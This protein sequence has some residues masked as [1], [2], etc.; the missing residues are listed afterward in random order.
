MTPRN[1]GNALFLANAV[2]RDAWRVLR[3]RRAE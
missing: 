3:G 1:L 2:L